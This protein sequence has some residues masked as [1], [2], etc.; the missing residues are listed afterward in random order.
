MDE[1]NRTVLIEKNKAN[2][3]KKILKNINNIKNELDNISNSIENIKFYENK[4]NNSDSK[5]NFTKNEKIIITNCL[6]DINNITNKIVESITKLI[7]KKELE[8]NIE[9]LMKILKYDFL[10]IITYSNKEYISTDF[11]KLKIQYIPVSN[12]KN[13]YKN[14]LKMEKII[15]TTLKKSVIDIEKQIK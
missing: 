7:K 11:Y 6:E 12:K 1:L 5:N 13:L 15:N 10:K 4:F 2:N 14:I 9:M 3:K 8:S